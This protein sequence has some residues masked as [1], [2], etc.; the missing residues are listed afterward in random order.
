[1]AAGLLLFHV[2]PPD[3]IEPKLEEMLEKA[4]DL[5]PRGLL[6]TLHDASWLVNEFL[7][8]HPF[9][10]GNSRTARILLAHFLR[11]QHSALEEIPPFF[12]NSCFF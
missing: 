4:R 7:H 6:E 9:E 10:D 2:A 12:L 1:M 8:I 5:A 3:Q 11:L